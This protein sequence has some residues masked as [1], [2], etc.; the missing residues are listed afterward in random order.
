MQKF[1]IPRSQTGYFT[2]QQLVLAYGQEKLL[3]FIQ[4]TFSRE[5]F[6]KQMSLKGNAFS[7]AQRNVLKSYFSTQ[8]LGK[9]QS[10]RVQK[11][12]QNIERENCFTITTGHQL[13]IFT[14]PIFMMYKILH[15]IRLTEELQ[16]DYPDALFVPVFWMASEDHD[17]EEISGIELFNRDLIWQT[18]QSGAVGRFTTENLD[19]LKAEIRNAFSRV[20]LSQ[21]DELLKVYSGDSLAEATFSLVNK[22]FSDYGLLILNGDDP[23]LKKQLIPIIHKELSEEFSFK[24]VGITN[25]ALIHDGWKL[26]ATPR[27]VNMF[28]LYENS[29]ERILKLEDGFFIEGQGQRSLSELLAE[30]QEYPERFSPNV[31][32]RPLYQELVLP[33]L[34]YVG[35]AGEMSY[36]LQ[37][38]GVFDQTH[39]P[40]P[41]IQVRSSLLLI[42]ATTSKKMEKYSIALEDMFKDVHHLKEHYLRDAAADEIDFS[43]LDEHMKRLQQS[44]NERVISCDESMSSYAEAEG[45]RLEKSMQNI[46]DKIVKTVKQR[47]ETS[48][49]AIEQV[50]ERVLPRNTMQERTVSVFSMAPDGDVNGLLKRI[51][52][53]IDPFDPDFVV[54]RS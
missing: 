12:I 28:Y 30:S 10:V 22:L 24:A 53:A 38:K 21:I 17:F 29:R 15:V 14:G 48:L 32:L 43:D 6:E 4:N 40:Y 13:N 19:V 16:K 36:W 51:Y 37:L 34:C 50:H 44:I 41:L 23:E 54:L 11:N 5:H 39:V 52:G 49:R 1:K 25:T 47:H 18:T 46:K 45:V 2:E 27:E 31:I 42:D 20:D 33:N 7:A 9:E 3:A 26:Q 35:G 8:Y